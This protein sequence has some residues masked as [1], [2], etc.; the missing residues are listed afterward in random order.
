[1]KKYKIIVGAVSFLCVMFFGLLIGKPFVE[2]VSQPE[3][4]RS[5][6]EAKG[7]W[8]VLAF[9]GMN[10][11][12]VI[13]A[14]IPAGPFQMG[15]GYAFGFWKGVLICD[16]AMT[17]GSVVVFCLVRKFGYPLVDTFV[18]KQKRMSVRFLQ[19]PKKRDRFVFLFFL[20]PG[21]PKDVISYLVGLTDMKFSIWVFINAVGRIP[22]IA[23]TVSSGCAFGTEKY[24]MAAILLTVIAFLYVLGVILYYLKNRKEKE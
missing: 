19:D 16:I 23:L 8:G 13:L 15:A 14:V 1:M 20:L 2:F 21:T 24:K 12:Q 3:A 9:V 4:F 5:W 22:A 18:S 10:M 6:I 11:L 7:N 17:L